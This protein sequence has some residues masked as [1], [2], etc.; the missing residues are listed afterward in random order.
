[1][2]TA[3]D[4]VPEVLEVP[5]RPDIPERP[6]RPDVKAAGVSTSDTIDKGADPRHL[7]LYNPRKVGTTGGSVLPGSV[8]RLC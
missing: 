6:E 2:E 7:M 8:A 1:M 5:E 4:E 3:L